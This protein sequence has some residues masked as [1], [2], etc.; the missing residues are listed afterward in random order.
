MVIEIATFRLVDDADEA[1]FITADE[2]AQREFAY[3]Q[4]G[5]VR[6]TTARGPAGEWL[7]LTMWDSA[8]DAQDAAMAFGDHPATQD[9]RRLVDPASIATHRYSTLN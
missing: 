2:R 8:E 5:I 4:R 3:Q 1:A 9:F 7:V 6:R